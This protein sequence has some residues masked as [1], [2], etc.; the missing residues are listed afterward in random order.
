MSKRTTRIFWGVVIAQ[1]V[2]LLGWAGYHENLR[3]RAPVILL[4]TRPVD[5]RDL[6]RG[7]YMVLGY[8]IAGIKVSGADADA[9]SGSGRQVWVVLEKRG[10]YHEAV[11]AAYDMPALKPG[12]V[13]VVGDQTYSG[14]QFGIERYFVPE[15][16]GTPAF[17][18]L[19][20]EAAVSP[21][22]R[23]FIKRLLLDGRAYP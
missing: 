21:T 10:E 23:L 16:K 19:E 11:S 18:R 9:S 8:D 6:L 3:Q 14:L 12:Q 7:D 20:V 2:F 4:K 13:L 15:G 22:R 1:L 5:P 17:K